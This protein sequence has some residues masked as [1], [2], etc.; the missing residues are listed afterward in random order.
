VIAP[1]QADLP[2]TIPDLDPG[3]GFVHVF[4]DSSLEV[5]M[6]HLDTIADFVEYLERKERLIRTGRLVVAAGEEELLA[7]YLWHVDADG[8]HDFVLPVG[9]DA[10]ALKKDGFWTAFSASEERQAELAANA[11][12]YMWDR[13]LG[14][15][16]ESV[17]DGTIESILSPTVADHEARL[18]VL[19]REPRARRRQLATAL[20][21]FIRSNRGSDM[22]IRVVA[23]TGVGVPYYVFVV[24]RYDASVP[25]PEYRQARQR[26]L[27]ACCGCVKL[28][29]PDAEDIVGV[30][31]ESDASLGHSEDVMHLDARRW[32]AADGE[33]AR[34]RQEELGIFKDMRITEVTEAELRKMLQRHQGH[35]HQ[36][37]GLKSSRGQAWNRPLSRC[38]DEAQTAASHERGTLNEGNASAAPGARRPFQRYQ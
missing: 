24:L 1:D 2:F 25:H 23:P 22:A 38:A 30:A 17:L 9:E 27:E 10:L 5:V 12:S 32:T 4:D 20:G 37:Q 14:M 16:N 36:G 7:Y 6:T 21:T 29:Y 8:K 34:K 11:V 26:L 18:R 33:W 28:K 3:R 31:T 19:A 35:G 15:F 13:M